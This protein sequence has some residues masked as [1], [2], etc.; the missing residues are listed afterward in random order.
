MSVGKR[1]NHVGLE[2]NHCWAVFYVEK[3]A[4]VPVNR[5]VSM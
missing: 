3:E 4:C 2:G 1:T 5:V